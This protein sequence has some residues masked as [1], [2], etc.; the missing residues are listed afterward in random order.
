MAA[1]TTAGR[2]GL[3]VLL[4]EETVFGGSI[5]VLERLEGY[6]GIETTGGWEFTQTMVK[7]A[8][9]AG[10]LLRDSIR[11]TGVRGGANSPFVILCSEKEKFR[12]RSVI[13]CSGGSPR[14][15]GLQEEDRLARRCIHT[16]AQCAG[17]Y[18][19]PVTL[20]FQP[21]FSL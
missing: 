13:V 16:C 8:E 5:A 20:K 21:R 2:L 12:S 9:A 18:L 11:V 3:Q 17:S 14:A 1:A 10:C 19:S 7:Q 4:L 6:P 15:L